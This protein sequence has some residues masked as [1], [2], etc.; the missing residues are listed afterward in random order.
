MGDSKKYIILNPRTQA[1]LELGSSQLQRIYTEQPSTST[2]TTE[3]Q[4][5]TSTATTESQLFTCITNTPIVQTAIW[6]HNQTLKLIDYK[7]NR[8]RVGT[9]E[10]RNLKKMWEVI[11]V[12]INKTYK[13]IKKEK[14]LFLMIRNHQRIC[15]NLKKKYYNEIVN[16]EKEKL[17]FKKEKLKKKMEVENKKLLAK[18]EEVAAYKERTDVLKLF[19]QNNISIPNV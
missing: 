9:L 18:Q 5:S 7:I 10:V 14:E 2:A 15:K 3:P 17:A 19:V 16:T 11:C 12:E 13:Y 6:S 4:P 8:K 1:K